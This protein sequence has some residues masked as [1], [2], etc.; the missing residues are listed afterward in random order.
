MEIRFHGTKE[1]PPKEEKKKKT[2]QYSLFAVHSSTVS[3]VL[4]FFQWIEWVPL[5]AAFVT[6]RWNITFYRSNYKLTFATVLSTLSLFSV[7]TLFCGISSHHRQIHIF[8]DLCFALFSTF[9]FIGKWMRWRFYFL[10]IFFFR[11]R[12]IVYNIWWHS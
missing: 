6:I 12:H 10:S 7:L 2:C 11:R 3:F 1:H 8:R 9:F 5:C 4:S